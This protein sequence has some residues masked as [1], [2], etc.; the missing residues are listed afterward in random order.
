MSHTARPD[1]GDIAHTLQTGRR[2]MRHRRAVVADGPEGLAEALRGDVGVQG[3]TGGQCH[4]GRRSH[5]GVVRGGCRRRLHRHSAL[6]ARRAGRLRGSGRA[7]AGQARAAAGG[8]G[9]RDAAPAARTGA[10]GASGPGPSPLGGVRTGGGRHRG[11]PRP[12][13]GRTAAMPCTTRAG[14]GAPP[15]APGGA[16][17]V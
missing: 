11:R 6:P 3:D 5:S 9:R 7:R 17:P 8:P 2:P 1:V 16:P 14:P 15:P 12:G 10:P 13:A 4:R